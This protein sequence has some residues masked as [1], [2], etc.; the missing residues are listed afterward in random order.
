MASRLSTTHRWCVTGTPI[1]E[2][3]LEDIAGLLRTLGWVGLGWG[4]GRGRV[5]VG[6]L[7]QHDAHRGGAARGHRRIA[8]DAR[9]GQ[10]AQGHQCHAAADCCAF[11]PFCNIRACMCYTA[12]DFLRL[13]SSRSCGQAARYWYS[14]LCPHLHIFAPRTGLA[15]IGHI[16]LTRPVSSRPS[17]RNR[18]SRPRRQAR[19]AAAHSLPCSR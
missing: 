11:T 6:W 12:L 5:G 14:L 17:S 9:V 2:G 7:R 19:G 18:S 10:A 8:T 1:G 3:Q 4:R 15:C 13:A 16:L